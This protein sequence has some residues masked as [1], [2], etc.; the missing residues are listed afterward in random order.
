M[1]RNYSIISLKKQKLQRQGVLAGSGV[2]R[3]PPRYFR[4]LQTALRR[5]LERLPAAWFKTPVLFIP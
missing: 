3:A 5:A 1:I 2:P 4:Y